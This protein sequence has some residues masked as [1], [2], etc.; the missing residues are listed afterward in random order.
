MNKTIP[1]LCEAALNLFP[2]LGYLVK[3]YQ[4]KELGEKKQS[5]PSNSLILSE[6]T[7][8]C[9]VLDSAFW[10]TTTNL[11]RAG[12]EPRIPSK[13][14]E[15]AQKSLSDESPRILHNGP[16]CSQDTKFSSLGAAGEAQTCSSEENNPGITAR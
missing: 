12:R 4:T 10:E 14:G 15:W 3:K 2:A 8:M 5:L 16:G 13:I 7:L 11:G 9:L 6:H 1:L